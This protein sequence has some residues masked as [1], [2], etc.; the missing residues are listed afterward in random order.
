[1][2][3]VS[4][5]K[6]LPFFFSFF[7]RPNLK[8]WKTPYRLPSK[9]TWRGPANTSD[10]PCG[11][12]RVRNSRDSSLLPI[13]PRIRPSQL[14]SCSWTIHMVNVT[15]SKIG[16]FRCPFS[17]PRLF[18]FPCHLSFPD[19][20]EPHLFFELCNLLL[21]GAKRTQTSWL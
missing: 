1:M 20:I 16:D 2:F 10:V 6:S 11:K 3:C 15:I 18:S 9:L 17:F 13:R 4:S 14:T 8:H 21:D 5:R 7:C 12:A 19:N